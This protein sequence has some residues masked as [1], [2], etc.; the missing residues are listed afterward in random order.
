MALTMKNIQ[1]LLLGICLLLIGCSDKEASAGI[2]YDPTK[3]REHLKEE[4]KIEPKLPT[5]FPVEIQEDEV[6]PQTH[7]ESSVYDVQFTGENDEK[8]ILLIHT[9]EV[10]YDGKPDGYEEITI[11]SHN[12]F[13]A[14]DGL[15]SSVHWT[16]GDY[17][18][19]FEYDV[20]ASGKDAVKLTK[21][22]L[23]RIAESFK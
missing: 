11:N 19:I 13:Y 14:E 16:D 8:F 17:H 1:I 21:E 10:T 18:Y 6:N 2:S 5:T 20:A 22:E 7:P 15:A 4:Q 23:I 9:K 3:I 12:G